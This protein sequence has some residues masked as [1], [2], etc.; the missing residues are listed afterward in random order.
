MKMYRAQQPGLWAGSWV[1]K[2]ERERANMHAKAS[3]Q[4]EVKSFSSDSHH[5][6]RKSKRPRLNLV[7]QEYLFAGLRFILFMVSVRCVIAAGDNITN[8][9]W[10]PLTNVCFLA[11]CIQCVEAG[12][13]W[14]ETGCTWANQKAGNV[15]LQHYS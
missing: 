1:K 5:R 4:Q 14:S 15:I 3:S 11:S 7:T 8:C 12:C 10:T 2:K 13:G 9:G 6:I